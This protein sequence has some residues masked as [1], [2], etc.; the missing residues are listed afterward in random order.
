MAAPVSTKPKSTSAHAQKDILDYSVRQR[1]QTANLV[2]ALVVPCARIYQGKE[3]SIASADQDTLE[4]NV[5]L[6]LT[7]AQYL[8]TLVLMTLCASH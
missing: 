2:P 4:I 8:V 5:T 7:H 6:L 1:N 3:T